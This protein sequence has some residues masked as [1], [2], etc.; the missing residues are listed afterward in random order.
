MEIN[1]PGVVE[2][3]TAAFARYEAALVSNDLEVL[4]A[5]FWD[6]PCTIRYG[7]GEILH[8]M[9]EIRAFRTARL[10]A[11]LMRA[12]E[13]TV[14]TTFGHDFAT[15]STLF[16]REAMVG[17]IGRQMQ[18]WVRMPEG[19]RVVAATVSVIPEPGVA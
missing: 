9:A 19:W 5:S 10:T 15:A 6:D 18:S 16:R 17:K 8:G 2:E 14:I 12:T 13:R 1:I 7:V 4:D 3:V 11:G